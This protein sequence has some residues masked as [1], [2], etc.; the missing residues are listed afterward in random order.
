MSYGHLYVTGTSNYWGRPYMMQH[1]SHQIPTHRSS[2]N[3]YLH[4]RTQVRKSQESDH[5]D[6]IHLPVFS[7]AVLALEHPYLFG[8]HRSLPRTHLALLEYRLQLLDDIA[9]PR[10]NHLNCLS[11]TLCCGQLAL[12][13]TRGRE[14]L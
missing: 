8:H 6:L 1:Q 10:L 5:H 7:L 14:T 2:N 11:I 3:T 9:F 13:H 4:A 12:S